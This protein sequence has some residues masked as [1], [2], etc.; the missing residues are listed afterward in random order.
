MTLRATNVL[1]GPNNAGKSTAIDALKALGGALRFARRRNPGPVQ[2][3]ANHTAIG[4]E[5]PNSSIPI[6]LENIHSDYE[7]TDTTV[8][9]S[10]DN[11][12][13]LLLLFRP[14]GKCIL[15]L[16]EVGKITRNT[17]DFA[18]NFPIGISTIPTLGPFEEEEVYLD[19]DTV[20]RWEGTRRSHRMFR[21]IWRRRRR[22]EFDQFKE[23]VE[24]TWPGMSIE[25]PELQLGTTTNLVMF[26]R[27]GRRDREIAWAGFGFQVWLQFLTHLL[28]AQPNSVAI[29]DEPD[30]YLHPDLQ[31][32]L[33]YLLKHRFSQVVLA[34]HSVEIINDAD[35]DEIITIDKTKRSAKH[36]TDIEGLQHVLSLLG[37]AQN[38]QLARLSKDKTII[39]FEGQDYKLVRRLAAK[40]GFPALSNDVSAT[41]IPIGGFA[42]WQR[43]EHVAWTFKTILNTDIK[44]AAVL[45][46]DYRC[47]E[48][49]IEFLDKIRQTAPLCFV[50][51]RKE[52]ENYL[53]VPG[54]IIRAVTDRLRDRGK[55]EI[56]EGDVAMYL[57]R[58][59]LRCTETVK[60]QVL[61]QTSSE[62]LR[63]LTKKSGKHQSTILKDCHSSIDAA[64]KSIEGR[65]QIVPGKEVLSLLNQKV[66]EKYKVSVTPSQIVRFMTPEQIPQ[67]MRLVFQ[68]L[69]GMLRS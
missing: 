38:V 69:T 44:M 43:I 47:S 28:R 52:L 15:I 58:A 32:R 45:D 1:V 26:C 62:A 46:R 25:F 36:V 19:D 48:E 24:E 41:I 29:I 50:W 16:E 55:T 65:V 34:T 37:S 68:S 40:A 31:R 20:A 61:A 56:K 49:I 22:E 63:Y 6:T 18:R 57:R 14:S 59:L 5:I 60:S 23:L 13:K 35:Q 53:L 3:I 54:A 12:N 9:F 2:G 17:R 27:E 51:D 42:Q 66:Q 67:D 4:Y 8:T 30:I 7:D 11:G 10:L 21:N 64:W 39:F 33:F